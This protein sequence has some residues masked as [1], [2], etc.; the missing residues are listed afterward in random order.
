MTQPDEPSPET[1]AHADALRAAQRR[2][3]L[4][5]ID[6]GTADAAVT[7]MREALDDAEASDP[8]TAENSREP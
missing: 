4:R 6:A 5:R 8:A 7:A 1:D 3:H 2:A